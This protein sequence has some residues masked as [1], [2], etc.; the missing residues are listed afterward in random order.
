MALRVKPPRPGVDIENG[1][2]SNLCLPSCKSSEHVRWSTI[3]HAHHD[4]DN[5]RNRPIV[6]G[7]CVCVVSALL[8]RRG[9]PCEAVN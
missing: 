8:Y 2:L 1:F 9:S 5:G 3:S 7:V 4:A 6:L